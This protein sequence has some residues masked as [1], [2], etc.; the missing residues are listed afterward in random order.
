MNQFDSVLKMYADSGL[1]TVEDW[2]TRGRD[3]EAGAKPR[4]DTQHRGVLLS[5]FTR[6]QTRPRARSERSA[7]AAKPAT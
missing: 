4:A 2:T 6:D 7:P 5:L 1:R 3:I